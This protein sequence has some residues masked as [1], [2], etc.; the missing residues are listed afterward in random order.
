MVKIYPEALPN[1]VC[2]DPKR[3]AEV[4]LYEALRQQLPN[5]WVVFYSVAWLG[6]TW[7]GNIPQDGETDFIVAHPKHG[8]L[9]IEVKGGRI[10]Y[11]GAQRQW[12][13]TDREGSDHDIDPF[14]Q[15]VR[16]KHVLLK[17]IKS[18]PRWSNEWLT[19]GHAVAFPYS[20]VTHISL[21]PE[22]S[23][24]IIIDGNDL[25]H[26]AER[27]P[28][29]LE[30]WNGQ[31]KQPFQSGGAL[32]ADLEKLLASTITLLNPLSLTVK[33]EEREI[34]RLTEEQFRLLDFLSRTRRAAMSGCAGSGKTT[35]AVEKAK[36]LANE[37]FRTLLTCYNE[38]L[39]RHLVEVIGN[40][41]HLTVCTFHQ[42]C[43]QMS[44]ETKLPLPSP[45][46]LAQRAA[47]DRQH[48]VEDDF[49]DALIKA[50]ELRPDLKYDAII[51]D[52][53]QDFPDTWWPAL[54]ECLS[55]GQ[56][57]IFYVFYDD[58]QRIY[59]HRG[60]ISTDLQR[61][62]LTENVRNT[63]TIHRA[64]VTYYRGESSSLPRGPI[65]RSIEIQHYETTAELRKLL[66]QHFQKLIDIERLACTDLVVLTPRNLEHS[67]L[68]TLKM[69]GNY[70]LTAQYSD[71]QYEILYTTI[72]NFKGLERRVVIVAELDEELLTAEATRDGLCYVALSRPRN[73]LILLGKQSVIQGLL[74][75]GQ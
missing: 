54:E 66:H 72:Q 75:A 17:K 29:I 39:A 47:L 19:L 32:I 7:D 9:L 6:R 40:R 23:P 63:R 69:D 25:P 28:A 61:F 55:K 43:H 42:L 10:S 59:E 36:R 15:V 73:H 50:V 8:I 53:G 21:P 44:Q 31:E 1:R 68:P 37:G 18:L 30:Y 5:N 33:D 45:E 22:A 11:S 12:I 4:Q 62:P 13:S 58:N 57:S 60:S 41:A 46:G 51:V 38:S 56:N 14:N 2:N 24:D 35:L 3:S 49:A 65:G 67:V 20:I 27:I 48:I 74:P 26:L 70:K 52:E 34:L 64:L 16:S 71:R